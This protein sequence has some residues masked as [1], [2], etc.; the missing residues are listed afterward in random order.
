MAALLEGPASG[1]LRA[2]RVILNFLCHLSGIAN[3]TAAYVAALG[4]SRTRLL[5]TRKTLPGLRYPEKYA[6]L[7]GGGRNHRRNLAEMLMLKDNHLDRA[8]GIVPAVEA[9]RRAFP[10]G[11]MPPLEIECR[12]LGGGP[13][14]RIPEPDP[15]HAR[16]HDPGPDPPGPVLDPRGIETELSGNVCLQSL[17]ELARLGADFISVGRITHS[18]PYADFSMQLAIVPGDN[19]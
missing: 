14:G 16:Q 17:P 5:D 13:P 7:A 1:L 8:G 19:P 10:D 3:L 18:A 9:L 11:S 2:E 6:V 12:T 15:H 4:D